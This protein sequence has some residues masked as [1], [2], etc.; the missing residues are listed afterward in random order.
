M[1]AT[2][3]GRADAEVEALKERF[4]RLFQEQAE[5]L[6][7]LEARRQGVFSGPLSMLTD[8]ASVTY[9]DLECE[10]FCCIA[11]TAA[12]WAIGCTSVRGV[13]ATFLLS[14]PI[15]S[16]FAAG[17]ILS[18]FSILSAACTCPCQ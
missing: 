16:P 6:V 13:W 17:A 10:L 4:E 5:R 12:C 15:P 9:R 11:R 3:A 2:R 1:L 18:I 8:T 14:C 7:V